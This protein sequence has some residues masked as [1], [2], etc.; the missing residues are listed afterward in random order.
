MSEVLLIISFAVN[1][2]QGVCLFFKSA[3]NDILKEYWQEKRN[4]KRRRNERI[5]NLR[6]HLSKMRGSSAHSLITMALWMNAT[7]PE[8]KATYK[9]Y[10]EASLKTSSE[11]VH[12]ARDNIVYYPD[13]IKSALEEF[14]ATYQ[15]FTSEVATKTM[16][17]ERLYEIT[18]YINSSID[19]IIEMIDKQRL[20]LIS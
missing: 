16:Y 7:D 14:F 2:V 11:S 4:R 10:F 6:K 17:K 18:D 20:R 19:D 5:I 13:N 9:G 12:F 15:E 8:A 1:V 3:L